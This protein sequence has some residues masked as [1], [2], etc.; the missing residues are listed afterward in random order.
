M[1]SKKRKLMEENHQP[2]KISSFFTSTGK[3]AVNSDENTSER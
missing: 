2:R 3:E 1:A